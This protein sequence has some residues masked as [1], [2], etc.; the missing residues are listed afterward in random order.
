MQMRAL[1]SVPVHAAPTSD[2]RVE[3]A[4]AGTIRHTLGRT[5]VL[6][7]LGVGAER[8]IEQQ[9]WAT[10]LTRVPAAAVA[11][12]LPPVSDSSGFDY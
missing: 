3:A 11:F 6:V 1:F 10:S 8:S 12:K 4:L 2:E 9:V 5:R 7:C